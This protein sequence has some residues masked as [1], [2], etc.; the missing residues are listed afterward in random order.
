[1]LNKTP[2]LDHY[3]V[4]AYLKDDPAKEPI[5]ASYSAP[6]VLAEAAHKT[7]RAKADFE[8]REISREEYERLRSIF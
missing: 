6:G 5:T 3:Y 1:M 8:L 2:E 7:G 4:A